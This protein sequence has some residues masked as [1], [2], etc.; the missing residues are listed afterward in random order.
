MDVGRTHRLYL[1]PG[2]FGFAELTG[3]KYF[4]HLENEL[5]RHYRARGLQL[6]CQV[7]ATPPTASIRERARILAH[8]LARSVPADDSPVHLLGHSTGGLDIRLVLSPS[9]DLGLTPRELEWRKRV[10]SVVL[11]N[12]PNY[13]T[14]LAT[15]FMTVSGNRAL[16]AIS[17]LTVLAL[18]LGE[19]SLVLLSR[20][21]TGL[22]NV[23]QWFGDDTRLFRRVTDA[24]LRYVDRDSRNALVAYLNQLRADQ[25]GLIQ[26]TPE[27]MDLLNATIID[28]PHVR[29]GCVVSGSAPA[30][31]RKLGFRVLSPYDALSA[32]LYRILFRATAANHER[33]PYAR[34]TPNTLAEMARS[35]GVEQLDEATN[36]GVVPTLSMVHDQIVWCGSADH[37]DI[38]GHFRDRFRPSTHL[39]WM[40]SAGQF[41][42]AEFAA[43][44][45]RVAQFEIESVY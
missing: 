20:V 4:G 23:D 43:M 26:M 22:G 9:A 37:L 14:P 38:I 33:Y 1:A 27:S 18:S 42:R 19:P 30:N 5:G 3:Y 6:E 39:D 13:G 8:N 15:Y 36:D 11:I 24:L 35:L 28:N 2:L 45:A 7:I 16:Y 17:L 29:Y 21:L 12:T 32:T 41:G 40:A 44:T 10:R 34:L 31:L 25:G